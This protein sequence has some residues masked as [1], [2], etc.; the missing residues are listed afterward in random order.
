MPRNTS[1][2]IS[3]AFRTIGFS[4][5]AVVLRL[6]AM[7]AVADKHKA[8]RRLCIARTSRRNYRRPYLRILKSVVQY[9]FLRYVPAK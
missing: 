8:R 1:V 7:T 2:K 5:A 9:T 4:L 6:R 3:S